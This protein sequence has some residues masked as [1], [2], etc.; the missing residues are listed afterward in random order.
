MCLLCNG[1]QAV[2][3]HPPTPSIT[4]VKKKKKRG[5][6][7][8][9]HKKHKLNNKNPTLS[10]KNPPHPQKKNFK[11]KVSLHTKPPKPNTA[12]KNIIYEFMKNQAH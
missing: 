5:V 2:F 4:N 12:K 8:T 1:S 7:E 10:K 3:L 9:N 11:P 6:Y